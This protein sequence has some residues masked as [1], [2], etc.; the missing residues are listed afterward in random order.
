MSVETSPILHEIE[1][2]PD[3]QYTFEDIGRSTEGDELLEELYEEVVM[4]AKGYYERVLAHEHAVQVGQFRY[5]P[6]QQRD[7]IERLDEARRL[8][9]NALC[10]KLRI[11]TRACRKQGKPT[12]WWYGIT[13]TQENRYRIGDWALKVAHDYFQKKGA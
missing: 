13:G 3:P 1:G 8:A 11:L 7:R 9:H 2:M 4:G 10:D 12:D 5:S 6:E